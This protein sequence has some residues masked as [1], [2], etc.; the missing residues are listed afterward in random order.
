MSVAYISRFDEMVARTLWGLASLACCIDAVLAKQNA[1]P[2][3][4]DNQMF[5]TLS[6]VQ[7]ATSPSV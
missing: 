2:Q 5:C 7:E 4:N 1:F 3:Y 6:A